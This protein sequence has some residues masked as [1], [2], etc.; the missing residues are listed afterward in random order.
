MNPFEMGVTSPGMAA[1]PRR[2]GECSPVEQEERTSHES[3][4]PAKPAL[5]P[6]ICLARLLYMKLLPLLVGT[7]TWQTSAGAFTKLEA[8]LVQCC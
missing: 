8:T 6:S 2:G 7:W 1:V 3:Q 5:P 4:G